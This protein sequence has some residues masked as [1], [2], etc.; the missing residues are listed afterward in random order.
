MSSSTYLT[1]LLIVPLFNILLDHLENTDE[2]INLDET[3]KEVAK[4]CYTKLKE[5][6]N[7]IDKTFLIA[8]ILDPRFK[9]HYYKNNK[10][11]EYIDTI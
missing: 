5:Y 1:L 2:K 11:E 3:I 6:Y 10:W 4:E 7:K 9:M 8:T